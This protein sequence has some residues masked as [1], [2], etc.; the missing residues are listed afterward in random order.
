M[1]ILIIQNGSEFD[2]S[3]EN[4]WDHDNTS[5]IDF[6]K[7]LQGVIDADGITVDGYACTKLTFESEE[8]KNWFLLKYS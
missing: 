4:G 1:N 8:Q 7:T 3:L 2:K 6:V 5:W